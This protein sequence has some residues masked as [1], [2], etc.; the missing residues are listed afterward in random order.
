VHPG[1]LSPGEAVLHGGLANEEAAARAI[2]AEP[3]EP[4]PT[5]RSG[6]Y[7][8]PASR[9]LRSVSDLNT[10]TLPC[11]VC[12]AVLTTGIPVVRSRG[13]TGAARW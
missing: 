10:S 13:S 7:G 9:S 5:A 4:P 2:N 8:R 11:P 12:A 3:W 1:R 6:R